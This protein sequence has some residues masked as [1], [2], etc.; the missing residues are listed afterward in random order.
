MSI[1]RRDFFKKSLVAGAGMAAAG[2]IGPLAL[3]AE[4]KS[5][6]KIRKA[7]RVIIMTF[8]GIRVDGL[9]KANTP[10]IDSLIAAGSASFST[11]V[12]M[13][14]ITLPNYTSHLT[15]AGPEV[16]GVATNG[17]KVDDYT[18]PAVERDADGYF[19]SVFKA[20]K[21]GVPGIKTGYY[22]NWGPLINP[23]NTKYIDDK[24][25]TADEGYPALYDRAIEYLSANRNEKLF[26]FV[27][28]GHTDEV[29]HA[30]TWMSPEYLRSIEEG[31]AQVGRMLSFLKA[32]G[33]YEESHI[34][35]ISDHGG[36]GK[37]HGG[38]SPEEMEVPW[39]IAGPGIK[40]GFTIQEANNTVN[41]AATV[42]KLFGAEQPLCW[43]GEVPMSIFD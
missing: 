28:N 41:T 29:G 2:M 33:L 39:V 14:S 25:L 5:R 32:E 15:G 22:W 9:A 7:K 11:R 10:N 42:V 8:D 43:T 17:W 26:M 3:E 30:S 37:G 4:A 40:K 34:M 21:D 35:F 18:L 24:L 27:Y 38:L 6:K 1:S 31:D 23:I 16:H 20:L 36:V 13:P 19:P 12:V